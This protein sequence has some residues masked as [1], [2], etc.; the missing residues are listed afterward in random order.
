MVAIAVLLGYVLLPSGL[1]S[2]PVQPG[3]NWM[4]AISVICLL[5]NL[6][7]QTLSAEVL[8]QV[9]L[10]CVNFMSRT[11]RL[12]EWN[13]DLS[14]RI[15]EKVSKAF[16]HRILHL[17][18]ERLTVLPGTKFQVRKIAQGG[19]C[20]YIE[21]V[22]GTFPFAHFAFGLHILSTYVSWA[23]MSF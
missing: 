16:T 3:I 11:I 9:M 6:I 19:G 21:I 13:S 1:G 15:I 7:N 17:M 18:G 8:I 10:W 23:Y 2:W 12:F 20:S 22:V 4:L 5:P 14:S